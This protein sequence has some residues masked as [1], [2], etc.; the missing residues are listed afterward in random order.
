MNKRLYRLVICFSLGLATGIPWILII[1]TLTAWLAEVGISKT[2]IGLIS[3][4]IFPYMFQ[5]LWAPLIDHYSVPFLSK[6]LGQKKAWLVTVQA[7]LAIAIIG[8]GFTNPAEHIYR[9][10]IYAMLVSFLAATQETIINS[11]R[12]SI[13]TE[14]EQGMGASAQMFGLRIG[15]L[16]CGGILLFIIDYLCKHQALCENFIN[17]KLG[18]SAMAVVILLSSLPLFFLKEEL[19]EEAAKEMRTFKSVFLHPLTD[20]MKRDSYIMILALIAI[21][22]LCDYFIYPMVNPFLVELGFSL[23]EVGLVAKTFSF[24]ASSLGALLAGFITHYFSI[25]TALIIAGVLQMSAN[26]MFVI[27]AKAGY[28]LELLYF[29][30]GIENICGSI[31]STVLV[32]YISSLCVGSK[33]SATQ[34]S[35]LSSLGTPSLALSPVIAGLIA[36][37][38]GWPNFFKISIIL[39]LPPILLLL[40]L[41]FLQSRNIKRGKY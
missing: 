16:I 24:I 11:Y 36:E 3:S 23:T 31:A 22:R 19:K 15:N 9:I 2:T 39:G 32:V 18:F 35:L 37:L 10:A 33:Y 25:I 38:L 4:M 34:Y 30:V 14:Q 5:F 26:I 1:G 6:L 29:T 41:Q 40:F 17:W 7:L 8:L 12:I 13:L 28:N 20:F 27:Q 21:Y